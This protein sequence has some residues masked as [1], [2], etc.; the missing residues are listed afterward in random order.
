MLCDMYNLL[1][2]IPA[3]SQGFGDECKSK[4]TLRNVLLYLFCER[5]LREASKDALLSCTYSFRGSMLGPLGRNFGTFFS[6][7]S[8]SWSLETKCFFPRKKNHHT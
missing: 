2:F 6:Q 3:N 1:K 8:F 4:G 7:L 5:D